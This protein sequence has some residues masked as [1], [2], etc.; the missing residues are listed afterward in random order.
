MDFNSWIASLRGVLQEQD[1]PLVLRNGHWEVA[2]RKALWGA[3]SSRIFDAHLDQFKDCAVE[4]LKEL[5]PQ[6][7]LSAEERYAA[8]IHGKVLK[9]SSGLRKGMAETLALLGNYG[10]ILTNCSQHKPESM[11]V[12]AIREILEQAD[13]Q[14]WGSLN[15]L[16]PTLAEAAPGEFLNTVEN[17]LRQAPCPFDELFAQEGNGI[18][19]RNYMTGLLWALEGLAWAEEHLV[20]VAVILAE[21]ASH[22]P[23]GNWANR[24]AIDPRK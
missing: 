3:V 23:G 9:H 22:D 16:L 1:N 4:V 19:G 21:L 24:P 14:L 13:W 17:A 2:D 7:E 15:D 11:A 6:F 18:S 8:G 5:D 20:R 12:L 10:D